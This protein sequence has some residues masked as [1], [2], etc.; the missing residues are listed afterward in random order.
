MPQQ[1]DPAGFALSQQF[2]QAVGQAMQNA[3]KIRDQEKKNKVEQARWDDQKRAGEAKIRIQARGEWLDI[4]RDILRQ[5]E[6]LIA[7]VRLEMNIPAGELL[8][9]KAIDEVNERL[10]PYVENAHETLGPSFKDVGLG[11]FEMDRYHLKAKPIEPVPV[12]KPKPGG[13]AFF[14]ST[15]AEFGGRVVQSMGPF[16]RD[17]FLG[18]FERGQQGTIGGMSQ[19]VLDALTLN[20]FRPE[21]P[22]LGMLSDYIQ[23]TERE[24]KRRSGRR[25]QD[26]F[27]QTHPEALP[28]EYL[29][30]YPPDYLG[31]R[32]SFP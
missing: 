5:R 13:K 24:E 19:D 7:T 3:Y 6:E 2:A 27:R 14:E 18:K 1:I 17:E 23:E 21:Q 29:E 25:I 22:G 26:I 8:P 9:Q 16:D 30:P 12:P 15:P 10:R 32:G 11:G 31:D 20:A 4:D 28:P